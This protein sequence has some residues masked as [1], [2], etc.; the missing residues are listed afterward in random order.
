[1]TAINTEQPMREVEQGI[2]KYL[3]GNDFATSI[4]Q[5]VDKDAILQGNIDLVNDKFPVKTDNIG[6]AQVTKEKLHESLQLLVDYLETLPD[7]EYGYKDVGTLAAGASVTTS[8]AF[9]S[10]KTEAP[11]C[12]VTPVANGTGLDLSSY[13][14]YSTTANAVIIITNHGSA[15]VSNV[16]LDYLALSGR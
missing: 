10:A 16:T 9:D 7:I 2:A 4:A 1:M 13:V 14:Q 15:S 3:N 8:I 5:L 6:T 11:M 12:F